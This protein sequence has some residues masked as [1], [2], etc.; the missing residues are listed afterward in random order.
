MSR[1]LMLGIVVMLLVGGSAYLPVHAARPQALFS[2]AE[3]LVATSS[4]PGNAYA[5]GV[6]VFLTAP[7]AGDFVASGGSVVTASPISGD[8]L[9]VGGSLSVRASVGGDVRAFGGDITINNPIRGDVVA[10]GY[11]VTASGRPSGSVLVTAVN[12]SLLDGAAGPVTIYGNNVSLAGDFGDDVTIM[13]GGRI[14]LAPNTKI[15]GSLSYESPEPAVIPA[16]AVIDE[17][18]RYTNASYLPTIGTSRILILINVGFFVLV[19]LLG[20]LLLAGLL[21]GLFP[22][23]AEE[24]IERVSSAT[25]RSTMLTVLL[26]FGIIVATPILIVLLLFTFVGIG[27][28]FFG[29][30]FYLLLI[31]SALLYTGI[32]IGGTLARRYAR[33]ESILWR[34]GVLGMLVLSL[35]A[36]VPYIG[37]PVVGLSTLFTAGAL[38]QIFFAFAFPKEHTTIEMV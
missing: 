36:F 31:M 22:R 6:S 3:S 30:L 33:R 9:L 4:A 8:A 34:D 16:T 12:T 26:G 38:L 21:A 5:A 13:A 20:A 14:A 32:L 29:I 28:A 37:M 1:V 23:F 27:L 18:V 24:V 17:E 10:F 15:H 11:T 35:I 25:P 19:R 7:V 2:A